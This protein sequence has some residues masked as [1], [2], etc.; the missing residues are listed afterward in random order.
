MARVLFENVYKLFG[1]TTAV[2]NVNFE[3]VDGEFLV[4]VG[5]SGCGKT[6]TLRMLAGLEE[7][8]TGDIFIGDSRV[9]DVVPSERDVAMVFQSYALYPHLTIYD[10]LAYGLR[11]RTIKRSSSSFVNVIT[12]L[13]YVAIFSFVLML[14]SLGTTIGLYPNGLLFGSS[15]VSIGLLLVIYPEIRRQFR[16]SVISILS[17]FLPFINEYRLQEEKIAEQ[18]K[19]VANLLLIEEQLWKK[20][21]QLSGGQRQRVALGRAIIRRPKVFL[22]DEPL[23]NLDAALRA[24][25]RAELAR[26]QRQLGVTTIYVTHDQIEAMTLGHRIVIMNNGE[27]KQIGT[28]EEVYQRPDN[29]MVAGFI[30]SPAMNFVEGKIKIPSDGALF[31]SDLFT[32]SVP[33]H[34]QDDLRGYEDHSVILGIRP[35][36][37]MISDQAISQKTVK[38]KVGVLEPIGAETFVIVDLADEFSF[39]VKEQGM[40]KLEI[41][42]E[43]HLEFQEKEIQFFDS[44]TENRI[45]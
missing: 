22:M 44:V 39:I 14:D 32:I 19:E 16:N 21:K 25:T 10:N 37:I 34:F 41:D 1:D 45:G 42:S 26:L 3:V 36:H 17:G 8:T 43:I 11:A 4:L 38:A 29:K 35:E 31:V 33:S 28:P 9:N 40:A 20:P 2:D 18:V 27:I 15:V 13:V 7:I 6:T 5:P 24:S 30:G 12:L 23:S